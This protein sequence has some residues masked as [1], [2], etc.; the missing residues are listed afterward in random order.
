MQGGRETASLPFPQRQKP[1]LFDKKAMDSSL[2]PANIAQVI[3]TASSGAAAVAALE[4][5]VPELRLALSSSK[6]EGVICGRVFKRGDIA[7][8]VSWLL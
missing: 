6:T 3:G 8:N 1:H 4:A 5:L 7:F 2:S